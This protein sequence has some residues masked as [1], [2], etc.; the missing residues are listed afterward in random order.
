MRQSLAAVHSKFS[1]LHCLPQM[2]ALR[3]S[4]SEELLAIASRGFVVDDVVFAA[5]HAEAC[6]LVA[7]LDSS[8]AGLLIPPLAGW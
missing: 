1:M 6:A 8:G 7:K 3:L 4:E 2:G 5:T